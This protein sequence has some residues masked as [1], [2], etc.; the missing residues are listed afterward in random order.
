MPTVY[1]NQQTVTVEAGTTILEA[2]RSAEIRIPT[3]CHHPDLPP[4]A[5]CGIC[6]V[7]IE[8]AGR[9]LRACATPVR[10]GMRIT[11]HDPDIVQ[12][13]RTVLEA[14]LSNHPN[15]CLTCRRN[16]T[17]ELQKLA[18]DF[19]IDREHLPSLVQPL[20]KD[21]STG[22]IDLDPRKCVN[23]GRCLDVC[24]RVQN[25]WALCS[26]NRGLPTRV[27]P[28]G[29]IS[30]ADS[31]C[32]R[33]G[34]C[35]AHCPVGAITEHDESD[36]VWEAL[37][38]PERI[39]IAQ[40]APAVQVSMGEAFGYPP[41]TNLGGQI[42][43][44]LRRIGFRHVFDT[45]FGADVT[46]MEEASEFALRLR[47]H[48]ERL[49]LITT[50]CPSWVDFME[51]FHADMIP[52]FSSCKSPHAIVGTLTKTWFA[53]R[54]GIDP[55]KIFM[56]SIM[57]CTS[58]KYEIIRDR[59]MYASGLQDV[60]VSI[61]SRELVRIIRQSGVQFKD[62]AFLDEPDDPLGSHSGAGTIFAATGG[63]MEAALRT[64]HHLLTDE[65]LADPDLHPI[66]GLDG[67]KEM[68]TTIAGTE[69]RVAVAHGC[70]H[71]ETVLQRI[72]EARAA[73]QELP[74]HFVEVMAC[75]GGCIGG[76]GQAWMVSNDRRRARSEG[77][78]KADRLNEVRASHRNPGVARLYAEFLGQPLGET[79]HRLLH[80]SYQDRP[81]YQ[82]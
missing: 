71:V 82:R 74:Y 21:T 79:A 42:V 69:I 33:C 2:A 81:H 24:Q 48:P 60:D 26:L 44:A 12:V 40:I 31:P 32:I 35:S 49:P 65:D 51:K 77:L 10:D 78:Y 63:V 64:A 58:K 14:I 70:G 72:R 1:I 18:A 38:D 16:G 20:P 68:T 73:G 30:L 15:E 53:E 41:G 47:E 17:C 13:R 5:A 54:E 25:V 66:R 11:T 8:G 28:A 43:A 67:I 75:P 34:Q 9:M 29:D 45:T 61:T 39:C 6:V 56:V 27:A 46:I 36:A 7:R 57:P 80:T 4:T 23:C 52:H 22:S 62:L 55:E 59:S 50:C 76:G 37:N 3:L 19:G